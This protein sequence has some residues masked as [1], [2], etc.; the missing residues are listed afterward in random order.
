MLSAIDGFHCIHYPQ[1]RRI[2]F[3]QFFVNS[4][5]QG[6]DGEFRHHIQQL[7]D[8]GLLQVAR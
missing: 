1:F 7:I 8:V 3:F 5:L 6:A 2:L 4:L